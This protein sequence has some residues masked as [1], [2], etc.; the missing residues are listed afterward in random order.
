MP[1]C[2]EPS[3]QPHPDDIVLWPDGCWGTVSDLRRGDYAWKSDD[4]E[5]IALEDRQRLLETGIL[6]EI[7]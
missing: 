4:Y 1:A 7:G 6:H 3:R 2:T 5:V